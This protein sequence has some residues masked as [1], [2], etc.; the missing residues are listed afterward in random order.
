MFGRK[1][2]GFGYVHKFLKNKL[3]VLPGNKYYLVPLLNHISNL[4]I[5]G[6]ISHCAC[7]VDKRVEFIWQESKFYSLPV[8]SCVWLTQNFRTV[9]GFNS[10]NIVA[11]KPSASKI[12]SSLPIASHLPS[13]IKFYPSFSFLQ[14]TKI[15]PLLWP[16]KHR[17]IW[18]C[19]RANPNCFKRSWKWSGWGKNYICGKAVISLKTMWGQRHRVPFTRWC[20]LPV[21]GCSWSLR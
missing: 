12:V 18:K 2:L 1:S 11:R 10:S 19:F 8:C 21:S 20:V 7:N 4:I 6:P 16:N 9:M 15:I 3:I 17:Q 5:N 13:P 14:S